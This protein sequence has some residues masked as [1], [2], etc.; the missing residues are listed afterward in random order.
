M[1][2]IVWLIISSI[3]FHDAKTLKVP[4]ASKHVCQTFLRNNNQRNPL[5]DSK[6]NVAWY[7][8]QYILYVYTMYILD[9]NLFTK[10][11]SVNV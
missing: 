10:K 5:T 11:T 1:Y 8:I 4:N 6:E 3:I 2:W 7:V 9:W